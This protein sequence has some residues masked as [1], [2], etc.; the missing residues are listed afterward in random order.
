MTVLSLERSRSSARVGIDDAVAHARHV[1][2]TAL[3]SRVERLPFAPDAIAFLSASSAA[4]GSGTLW[5]QPAARRFRGRR[6][7]LGDA[8]D[9][10]RSIRPNIY[11]DARAGGR[12]S[13]AMTP[14][15]SPPSEASPSASLATVRTL[16]RLPERSA[17]GSPGAHP[18]RR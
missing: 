17:C 3:Y 8:C 15:C 9:R 12:G 5:E 11:G 14:L 10:I 4:L 7:G 2:Q 18:E 13:F 16:E 6:V 1:G